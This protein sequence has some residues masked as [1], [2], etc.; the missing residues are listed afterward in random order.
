MVE[1]MVQDS[2][3]I[4]IPEHKSQLVKVE[5]LVEYIRNYVR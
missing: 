5:G 2:V 3:D 1:T 4:W